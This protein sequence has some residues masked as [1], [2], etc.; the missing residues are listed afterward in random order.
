M[1]TSQEI[2]KIGVLKSGL[3]ISSLALAFSLSGLP[4]AAQDQPGRNPMDVQQDTQP[5]GS[6]PPDAQQP[7][8]QPPQYQQP[9]PRPM[10]GWRGPA[11][12]PQ[13][14]PQNNPVPA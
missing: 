13:Y 12:N 7:D 4:V 14:A 8:A 5:Q 3:A 11:A 9:G 6:Q 2:S 10:G 1:K